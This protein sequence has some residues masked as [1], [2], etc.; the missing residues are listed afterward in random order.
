MSYDV[1]LVSR[2]GD[3]V[4]VKRFEEGGTYCIGGVTEASLNITY[5]YG[6]IFYKS[7]DANKGIYWLNG[8]KAKRTIR[9][10]DNAVKRLGT[11]QNADYWEATEGNAGFALSILLNWAVKNPEA[12][13]RV[14]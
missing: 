5:N 6:K 8:K 9:R 2:N 7:L 12:K 4:S 3:L 13:W 10:L 14:T 11:K 1:E